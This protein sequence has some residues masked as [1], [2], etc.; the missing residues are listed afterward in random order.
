MRG[1]KVPD[2]T[3]TRVLDSW[4]LLEWLKDRPPAALMETLWAR[5]RA[6][7]T[8]LVINVVNLGE[9]FYLTAK[10]RNLE[11]A[12][13]VLAELQESPLE[14]KPASDSLVLE[15]ARLKARFPISYADAFAV[16]MA[17]RERAPLVTGDPDL[18]ILAA[19]GLVELEWVGK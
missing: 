4:I 15:A 5:A 6:G 19:Q 10:A 7:R 1:A 11:A 2:K 16:A 8:R 14:V 12:E 18:K 13:L 3:D 17:A 9:V